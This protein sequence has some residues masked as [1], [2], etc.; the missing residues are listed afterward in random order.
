MSKFNFISS[1]LGLFSQRIKNSARRM[2]SEHLRPSAAIFSMI[3]NENEPEKEEEEESVA[4]A[5]CKNDDC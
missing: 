3:A 1:D 4:A 5:K 2:Y